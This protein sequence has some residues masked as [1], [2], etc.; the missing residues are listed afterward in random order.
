MDTGQD[1][2]IKRF[3]EDGKKAGKDNIAVVVEH[4]VSNCNDVIMLKDC[5][6]RNIYV[7]EKDGVKC[8]P[9]KQNDIKVNDFINKWVDY[10]ESQNKSV[11]KT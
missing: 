8:R 3:V 11:I 6:V 10:L 7:Y 4:D 2:L 9:P 5:K 1:L